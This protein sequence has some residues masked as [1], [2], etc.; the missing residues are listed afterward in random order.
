MLMYRRT[1]N[2][3][4]IDYSDSDFVGFFDSRKSTFGFIY[5]FVNGVVS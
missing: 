4:V 2:L 3:K 1:N 5:T